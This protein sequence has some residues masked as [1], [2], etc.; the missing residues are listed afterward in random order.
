MDASVPATASAAPF[1]KVA[2]HPNAHRLSGPDI[3]LRALELCVEAGHLELAQAILDSPECIR[4]M[5]VNQPEHEDRIQSARLN[6]AAARV[7]EDKGGQGSLIDE[8]HPLS[9]FILKS[10]RVRA[11]VAARRKAVTACPA[12]AAGT[13]SQTALP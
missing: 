6:L 7:R 5:A 3:L 2:E 1:E 8:S 13:A 4:M 10:E 9:L 11:E 12:H